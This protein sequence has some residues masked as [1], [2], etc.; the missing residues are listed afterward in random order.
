MAGP[1]SIP[2]IPIFAFALG[3]ALIHAGRANAV[4]LTRVLTAAI[5]TLAVVALIALS[6]HFAP[7]D[8]PSMEDIGF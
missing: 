1:L 5:V 8:S 4:T 6:F 7:A 3:C 2:A